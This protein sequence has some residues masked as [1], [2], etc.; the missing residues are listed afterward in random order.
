MAKK[1]DKTFNAA[2]NSRDCGSAGQA[3][4][5]EAMAKPYAARQILAEGARFE[6][7]GPVRPYALASRCNQPLCHPSKFFG[8]TTAVVR[9]V[10]SP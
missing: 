8:R 7:A 1:P 3:A 6:L 9:H 4:P 2:A 10:S 5:L